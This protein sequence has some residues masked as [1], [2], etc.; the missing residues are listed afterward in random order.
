[1]QERDYY[2]SQLIVG[3]VGVL[4]LTHFDDEGRAR[5]VD[6]SGKQASF[7]EAKARGTVYVNSDTFGLIMRKEMKKGDVLAVAQIAGIMAA[8]HASDLI[9]MC[10]PIALTAAEMEFVPDSERN[11]IDIIAMVRCK[12]ETGVEMEA[13]TAVSAAA[14]TI[15]DMCKAVQKDIE[16]GNIKLLRKT[17]GSSGEYVADK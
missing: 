2:S 9:P 10:H 15:Y 6:V 11:A 7:R 8:K 14:L 3:V 4:E 17:G 1:M 5:M 13:L 16:I 12:G